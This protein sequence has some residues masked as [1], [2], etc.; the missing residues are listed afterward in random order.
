MCGLPL[1][2]LKRGFTLIE[3]L[4][5]IAIIGLLLAI[6]IPSLSSARAQSKRVFCNASLKSLGQ[7]MALYANSNRD[8]MVPGRLPK[9]D[10]DRWSVPIEGGMK[11]RP[12]FLAMLGAE[13]GIP[14]F[15]DPQAS[16]TKTDRF[17]ERGDRQNY[18]SKVYVCPE[19][20]EWV[21]ERNGAYGYNYQFLGN[22]RLVE[23]ATEIDDFK[24]WP[25][26]FSSIKTPENMIAAGDCMGTA[27]SFAKNDRAEY[28]D[29][30]RNP[31]AYGEEGF[32]LDPPF[33]DPTKGEM[34]GLEEDASSSLRTAL[35]ERHQSKAGVLWLDGHTTA[36]TLADAGYE[37]DNDGKVLYGHRD[38]ANNRKW[39]PDGK[40]E[41]WL[42]E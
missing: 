29:N 34:A 13:V 14:A 6:L 18:S 2:R 8:M 22:S 26:F 15:E 30:G 19:V 28:S 31:A 23:G 24:N 3:L 38:R 7:G 21:D 25:V 36:E 11:Y 17:G 9:V 10:N 35:H 20:P 12:T 41:P 4:V 33:V 39:H 1:R 16:A 32:N 42:S 37:L 27:A 40:N 5:V